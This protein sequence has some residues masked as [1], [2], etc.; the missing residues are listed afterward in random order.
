MNFRFRPRFNEAMGRKSVGVQADASVKKVG[1]SACSSCSRAAGTRWNAYF[2][3][4][5]GVGVDKERGGGGQ[6]QEKM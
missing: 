3:Y 4:R 1:V 5:C 2:F 6:Y